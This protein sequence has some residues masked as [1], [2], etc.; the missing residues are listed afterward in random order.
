[1]FGDDSHLYLRIILP[2]ACT[3]NPLSIVSFLYDTDGARE[4]P[5]IVKPASDMTLK[6]SLILLIDS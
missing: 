4:T 1:V 5:Y 2:N 3:H 6:I